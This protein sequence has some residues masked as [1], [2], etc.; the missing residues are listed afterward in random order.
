MR[1]EHSV[2]E[3]QQSS[4]GT[5]IHAL[6]DGT[7]H[8][9]DQAANIGATTV[10]HIG[11]ITGHTFGGLKNVFLKGWRAYRSHDLESPKHTS[12]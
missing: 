5:K 6:V 9:L 7:G 3:K 8:V 12:A 2:V 1:S 4:I 11:S 10:G